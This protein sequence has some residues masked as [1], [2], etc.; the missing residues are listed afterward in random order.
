[1]FNSLRPF[2]PQPTR[3]FCP[4]CRGNEDSSCNKD[5]REV[6][7]TSVWH[8]KV[9]H[10]EIPLTRIDLKRKKKSMLRI[11]IVWLRMVWLEIFDFTMEQKQMLLTN[12]LSNL[13][14]L[15]QS[16]RVAIN[17]GG[18][19]WFCPLGTCGSDWRP[20]RASQLQEHYQHPECKS[21]IYKITRT[22]P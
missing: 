12:K 21:S 5:D 7:P 4:W 22:S 17:W 20:L 1:M 8:S 10:Q 6:E 11:Q 2:G 9:Q 15:Y 18:R 13:I 3:L 14:S 19:V 16:S